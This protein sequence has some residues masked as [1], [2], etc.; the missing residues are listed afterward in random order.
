MKINV[1]LSCK[2]GSPL[3]NDGTCLDCAASKRIACLEEENAQHI[4]DAISDGEKIR[5]LTQERDQLLEDGGRSRNT[6]WVNDQATIGR[7][8][9]SINDLTD[10]LRQRDKEVNHLRDANDEYDKSHAEYRARIIEDQE[11]I[12]TLRSRLEKAVRYIDYLEPAADVSSDEALK[13]RKQFRLAKLRGEESSA[14]DHRE[15]AG[16]GD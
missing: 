13:L 12:A 16:R 2:C 3:L 11:E 10:K 5:F 8:A 15:V 1:R 9:R 4:I 7:L 6:A 14:T